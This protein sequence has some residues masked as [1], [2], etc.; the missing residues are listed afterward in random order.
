[1]TT[2]ADVTEARRTTVGGGLG[3]LPLT[4]PE[5]R[6]RR[7]GSSRRTLSSA[8]SADQRISRSRAMRV[9]GTGVLGP[10]R[11]AVRDLAPRGGAVGWTGDGD[12][13]A[14]RQRAGGTLGW[15]V[16]RRR[17]LTPWG[18]TRTA[19]RVGGRPTTCW[20]PPPSPSALPCWCGP[21]SDEPLVTGAARARRSRRRLPRQRRPDRA[22][23]PSTATD[24]LDGWAV[25]VRTIQPY[26][27]TKAYTCPG[28]HS[29]I[30]EGTGHL[31]V[32]PVV[33]PED[34]RHWHRSCW[35]R[36]QRRRVP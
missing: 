23:S 18:S 35:S 24:Q 34:R 36:R 31:V 12:R 32:V 13:P 21:S 3:H 9:D 8:R 28:C 10:D 4:A 20:S 2:W 22:S 26:Q 30:A 1:M 15:T 27:A 5:T 14:V 19:R 29:P 17:S 25:E 16:R 11:P 6:R 7:A 33:A